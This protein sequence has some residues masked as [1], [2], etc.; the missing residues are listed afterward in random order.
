MKKSNYSNQL[1]LT[2]TQALQNS[3]KGN[4]CS[5]QA[6][7]FDKINELRKKINTF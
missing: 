6:F 7:A 5:F 1:K 2:T 4:Q 3:L